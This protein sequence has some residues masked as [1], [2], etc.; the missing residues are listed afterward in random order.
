MIQPIGD[1]VLVKPDSPDRKS[2]E[3]MILNARKDDKQ[4]RGTI[5][6]VGEGL[7]DNFKKGDSIIYLKYG[8]QDIMIGKIKH[9]LIHLDEI[10]AIEK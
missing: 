4:S 2:K 9:V 6:A 3:G 5:I 1:R 7:K 8:P 10:L